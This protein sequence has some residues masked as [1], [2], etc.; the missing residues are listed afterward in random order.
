MR[1]KGG[2]SSGWGLRVVV[3]K[4]QMQ[5]RKRM[6][7][8][9]QSAKPKI[10]WSAE[11]AVNINPTAGVI[12]GRLSWPAGRSQLIG[13]YTETVCTTINPMTVSLT[14]T[15]PPPHPCHW[16]CHR[17][18]QR[19]RSELVVDTGQVE[20]RWGESKYVGKITNFT[21]FQF[22]MSNHVFHCQS[23]LSWQTNDHPWLRAK[24]SVRTGRWRRNKDTG[25]LESAHF[26]F[27]ELNKWRKCLK[28]GKAQFTVKHRRKK[29]LFG[30][31]ILLVFLVL[32]WWQMSSATW[33]SHY[34]ST[35]SI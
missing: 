8:S 22:I 34:N 12:K 3:Q 31:Y 2:G 32:Q 13:L 35:R 25:M 1:K 20:H 23:V 11:E 29:N 24:T 6:F 16:W 17:A 33:T 19:Y 28:A 26:G 15:S 7:W 27:R 14:Q 18:S 21:C 5:E 4:K 10:W 30:F 9:L